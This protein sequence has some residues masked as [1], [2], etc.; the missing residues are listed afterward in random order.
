[1]SEHESKDLALAPNEF[2]FCMDTQSGAVRTF[3]GPFNHSLSKT[4]QLVTFDDERKMF[5]PVDFHGA[6]TLKHVAP[7]G[8]YI[9]LKNPAHDRAKAHPAD[10]QASIMPELS[11]GEKVIIHGP[12]SF[13]AWPGQMVRVIQ[14]HHLKHNQYLIARVYNE[15]AA[16]EHWNKQLLKTR[17]AD[18]GGSDDVPSEE[19]LK[20][21]DDLRTGKLFVI[22]G[23]QVSFYM[24]TT[25]IEVVAFEEDGS[26]YHSRSG[27]KRVRR[28]VR[29][30]VTLE[31]LEYCL[32][33]DQSGNKRYVQGPAV[34]F[35]EP[36]EE[37]FEKELDDGTP[38]RKFRAYELNPTSG[39]YIKVIETYTEDEKTF[40]AGDELFITGK[41]TPIYFP[42]K[43]HSIIKYGDRDI[44]H[45][46]MIPEGEARYVANRETGK[47]DLVKG[48]T[49]FLP[50]PRTEIIVRRILEQKVCNLLFPGNQEAAAHN[51]HYASEA[52]TR[53]SVLYTASTAGA[54]DDSALEALQL[55]D[56]AMMRTV[57]DSE[58]ELP[59]KRRNRR[60]R[61]GHGGVGDEIARGN[62]FTPPRTLTLNTKYDGA[63][64]IDVWE[65]YA[66]MLTSRGE[67]GKRRVIVGPRTAML[68]YHEIPHA[69][70]LSTGKPKNTD[71]LKRT[72]YLKVSN[73]PVTD[74]VSV[75]TLDYCT[76]DIKLS[77]RVTFVGDDP[78][79][80]FA[81]EN[82]VKFLCDN[83]RSVLRHEVKKYGIKEFYANATAILRN[84]ILGA[85]DEAGRRAG[86]V[87][88]ENAMSVADVEVL[89]LTLDQQIENM[90]VGTQRNV[91][92]QQLMLEDTQRDVEHFKVLESLKREKQELETTSVIAH[93]LM[94]QK[95]FEAQWETTA[96]EIEARREQAIEIKQSEKLVEEIA[97][98]IAAAARE[99]KIAD[100]KALV[101]HM[102]AEAD[103]EKSKLLADA[104]AMER[105]ANAVSDKLIEA[106]RGFGDA[107][108]VTKCAEALGPTQMLRVL[109][110]SDVKSVVQGLLKGTPFAARLEELDSRRSQ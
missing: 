34:V 21:S 87:Y 51:Q 100:K 46:V 16:R 103:V 44:H 13:A 27:R 54:Y 24:P 12:T 92:A 23:D 57:V 49:V 2:A 108:L 55:N 68:E 71:N 82:Y 8:W 30:A 76:I 43:E 61:T 62:K 37:F 52:K 70:S 39:L 67:T 19:Q 15:E 80:W 85:K 11:V 29:D 33:I 58:E 89:R 63:V 56:T 32:L 93:E 73:N 35:P 36:T 10:N 26:D 102:Q 106:L 3:S 45:G 69:L 66:V 83:L 22:R 65:G 9:A 5:V 7:E 101:D 4:D 38:V 31:R 78:T 20:P 88:E 41:E 25:G 50:D 48:P 84:I 72:A 96:M 90:L 77:Y 97:H 94:R 60:Q 42:R 47:I 53:E 79:K 64:T 17:T 81:I 40:K 1:M 28:Y 109:G 14:G 105:K 99:V 98:Q 18:E 104:E 95:A 75:E 74:I 86:R 59:G 110:G 107:D 91:V 6:K